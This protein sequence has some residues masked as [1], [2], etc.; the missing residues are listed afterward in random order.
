MIERAENSYFDP[1]KF[2]SQV[3][4]L[5]RDHGYR[6]EIRPGHLGMALA[7]AGELLRSMDITLAMSME[8]GLDLNRE[9]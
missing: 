4:D 3:Q 8:D 1:Y 6:A 2:L 5:L 9:R 7:G